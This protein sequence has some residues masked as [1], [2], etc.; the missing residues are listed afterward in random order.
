MRSYNVSSELLLLVFFVLL[1]NYGREQSETSLSIQISGTWCVYTWKH[2]LKTG[3]QINSFTFS[4]FGTQCREISWNLTCTVFSPQGLTR[5]LASFSFLREI[6]R[7][8]LARRLLSHSSFVSLTRQWALSLT[9]SEARCSRPRQRRDKTN[10]ERAL[11]VCIN[12]KMNAAC[13]GLIII[14]DADSIVLKCV[15][16]CVFV[17][18]CRR[19]PSPPITDSDHRP[20][21]VL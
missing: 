13:E 20:N 6:E 12:R 7:V 11:K 8:S 1:S 2:D 10:W 17:R 15:G 16:K 21:I 4:P 9:L 14:S 18:V 19:P 5:S 3:T